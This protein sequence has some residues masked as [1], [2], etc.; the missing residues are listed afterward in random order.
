MKRI[1]VLGGQLTE[2]FVTALSSVH[3]DIR[4]YTYMYWLD[5]LGFLP[6]GNTKIYSAST[7][8]CMLWRSRAW[9]LCLVHKRQ[10]LSCV[11]LEPKTAERVISRDR[12]QGKVVPGPA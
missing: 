1:V 2:Q 7:S 3:V 5:L 10:T 9:D 8:R 6:R 11:N 4:W 12:L